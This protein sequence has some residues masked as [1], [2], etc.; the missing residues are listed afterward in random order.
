MEL[1]NKIETI[2]KNT[3][4]SPG[5]ETGYREPLIGFASTD[6]PIF[7]EIKQ[8]AGP[9]Q[10]HPKEIFPEAKTVIAFFLP[11]EK[12]L[13]K[14]NFKSGVVKE[15][16]QASVDTS[17][18]IRVI[19]EKLKTELAKEGITTIVPKVVFDYKNNGF[20]VLWS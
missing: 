18:L 16:I 9:Y 2:I 13:V 1:K 4:A 6:D 3:V 17:Y 12:E 5:T 10:L 20:N 15:S 19:N 7:I 8:I 11:F 14:Q